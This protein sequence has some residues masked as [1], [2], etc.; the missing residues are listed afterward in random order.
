LQNKTLI[1]S[2][3]TADRFHAKVNHQKYAD[4]QKIEYRFIC[5][6][7]I[8]NPYLIKAACISEML[9]LGYESILC[10]DDD[11]FFLNN[12]WNCCEI[13]ENY[14]Q[15]LIVTRGRAKKSG[16]TLFNAGVMFIK[17]TPTMQKIFSLLPDV[18]YSTLKGNWKHEWGPL[19]GQEQP[20]LIYLIKTIAP[21]K[22]KIIDYPGFNAHE[23]EFHKRK[24]FCNSNPP[25]VHIT[26]QNKSGKLKRFV[27][28]T[29]IQLF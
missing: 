17:N 12:N 7:D 13:F 15:D 9:N 5:R 14:T 28:N 18:R 23:I 24:D 16:T 29:G 1:L 11:V 2:A 27:N 21:E 4:F 19:T 6:T 26:G 20:R 25:I 10:V 8:Q 22:L 3:S